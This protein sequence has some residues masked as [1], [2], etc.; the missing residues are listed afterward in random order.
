M[1]AFLPLD[2]RLARPAGNAASSAGDIGAR[3]HP[4]AGKHEDAVLRPGCSAHHQGAGVIGD[5]GGGIVGAAM[6]VGLAESRN[7]A[8][9]GAHFWAW[10]RQARAA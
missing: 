6:G 8:R 2:R 7:D 10:E 1:C 9:P 4:T 3:S 5:N